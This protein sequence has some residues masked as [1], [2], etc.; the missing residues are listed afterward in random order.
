VVAQVCVVVKG[1]VV[2]TVEV[3]RTVDALVTEVVLV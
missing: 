2:E 3:K 1:A